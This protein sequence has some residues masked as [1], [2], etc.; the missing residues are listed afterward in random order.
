MPNIK[1]VDTWARRTSLECPFMFYIGGRGVG[2]TFSYL[3]G[4]REAFH[5][6]RAGKIIYMRLTEAELSRACRPDKNPYKKINE[7]CGFNIELKKHGEDATIIDHTDDG[8]IVIGSAMALSTFYNQRG[9]DFS[10]F[11]DIY[12]DEFIPNKYAR[13]TPAVKEAGALFVEAYETA[14]RNREFEEENGKPIYCVFT[15]N[16][17]SLDSSILRRFKVNAAVEH[18]QE[19]GQMR[20]RSPA[21]GVY[22]ELCESKEIADLKR[23]TA[24]YRAIGDDDE[25]AVINLENKFTDYAL[26]LVNKK[27]SIKEYRP[28]VYVSGITIYTHKSRDFLYI[29]KRYETAPNMYGDNELQKFYNTWYTLIVTHIADR[30]AEFDST[31]TYYELQTLFDTGKANR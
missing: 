22:V 15:A 20:Y 7:K 1:W 28:L 31:A 9:V 10:D 23:N 17:F 29:S 21:R 4:H 3:K 13:R 6:G 16:A 18:M 19:T 30:L 2:K 12:F 8:D 24:L 14:N 27:V 25:L 26:S 5:A 11:T